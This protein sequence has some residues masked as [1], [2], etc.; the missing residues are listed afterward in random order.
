VDNLAVGGNPLSE[1]LDPI[2]GGA[3]LRQDL[4]P[5]DIIDPVRTLDGI[6][7]G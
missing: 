5:A 7:K 2:G 6:P 4:D 1:R 3:T